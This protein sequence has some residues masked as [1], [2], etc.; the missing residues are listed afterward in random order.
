[1]ANIIHIYSTCYNF[2]K[3]A[4]LP[5]LHADDMKN[6][7]TISIHIYVEAKHSM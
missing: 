7:T 5:L 2:L 3:M 1:M 4:I 6:Q